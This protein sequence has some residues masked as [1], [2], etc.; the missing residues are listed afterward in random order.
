[1]SMQFSKY[2]ALSTFTEL[3][4]VM[5]VKLFIS[6]KSLLLKLSNPLDKAQKK[7]SQ[8]LLLHLS[9]RIFSPMY[10]HQKIKRKKKKSV[11]MEKKYEYLIMI[12]DQVPSKHHNSSLW[13]SPR[14]V[15]KGGTIYNS[16]PIHANNLVVWLHHS[17]NMAASM[18]MPDRHYSVYA[19]LF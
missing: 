18:I 6:S 19:K 9:P 1:M 17:P 2:D 4:F 10:L 12:N 15:I 16:Q 7:K 5:Q 14:T 13:I 8:F 11:I 3:P